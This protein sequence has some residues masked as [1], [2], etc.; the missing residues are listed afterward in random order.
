MSQNV[1]SAAFV[2][3][4]IKDNLQLLPAFERFILHW[5]QLYY[6]KVIYHFYI[7]LHTVHMLSVIVVSFSVSFFTRVH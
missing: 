7:I 4:A 6:F 3:G 2:I 1:S 5:Y